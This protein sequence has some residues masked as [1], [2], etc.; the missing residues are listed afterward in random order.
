MINRF[1][2]LLLN[3]D[4]ADGPG[5]PF[6]GEELLEPTYNVRPLPSY[7]RDL[8]TVL[9]GF[10]PDRTYLNYRMAQYERVIDAAR[11]RDHADGPQPRLTRTRTTVRPFAGAFGLRS[12]G[13]PLPISITG[14]ALADDAAGRC[15]T[16]WTVT[17]E[18]SISAVVSRR[19][20][21]VGGAVHVP[22]TI[23]SGVSSSIPLDR[24]VSCTVTPTVGA[25]WSV[26]ACGEPARNL[27]DVILNLEALGERSGANLFG[28]SPTEPY[29]TYRNLWRDHP[30]WPHRLAG[31]LLAVAAR[32]EALTPG[33]AP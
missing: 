32:T 21:T 13:S 24:F 15:L 11:L 5:F 29:L 19:T 9:F 12:E 31:L 23:E 8:H 7:L 2:T 1:R 22:F 18:S 6:P 14:R 30:H 33:S 3:V 26:E 20:P 10:S 4:P 27:A 25:S 28:F 17:V 16:R